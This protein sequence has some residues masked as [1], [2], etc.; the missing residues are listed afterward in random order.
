MD[1]IV[2]KMPKTESDSLNGINDSGIET[3]KNIPMLS[4]TKEE[5]QNSCDAWLKNG[6]PVEVHFSDFYMDINDIPSGDKLLEVYKQ[7]RDFWDDYM[8]ND[9]KVVEFFD[10]GISLLEK[11]KIRVLRISDYNTTGL[12]GIDGKSS[13]W[14]NLVKNRYVSDKPGYAGG[15][16]GI[17]KDAAFACSELRTVFYNTL[18]D[19]NDKAFQGT[20]RLPSYVYNNENYTGDGFFSKDDGN[21]KTNNAIRENISLEPGY[22]RN[23]TGMDKYIFGFGEELEKDNLKKEL[24]VSSINNYLY[25]FYTG[26]L[27]VKFDDVLVDKDHLE[28]LFIQYHDEIDKVTRD[29]YDVLK[30]PDRTET[31][32]VFDKDDV[33]IFVKLGNN[34]SRRAAVLR[35]TGMKVFDKDH[36]SGRIDF[37]AVVVLDGDNVNEYFK[38]LE[39][40]EHTQWSDYRSSSR[41]EASKKQNI[42]FSRL[43]EIIGELHIEDYE[44]RI[45]SEG[46]SEYLPFAYVTGKKSNSVDTLSNEIKEKKK[47]PKKKRKKPE[48]TF[49]EDELSFE[50]DEAGNIIEDTINVRKGKNV[51]PGPP[52]PNPDP[53]PTPDPDIDGI[54]TTLSISNKFIAKKEIPNNKF[55]FA[56]TKNSD[57]F[58]FAFIPKE[59]ISNCYLEVKISGEQNAYDTSIVNAKMDGIDA[60]I[61]G[62]K[63]Y[64]G[65]LNA[66]IKHSVLFNLSDK[67]EYS[68]EVSIY[69]S[70][71]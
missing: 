3:Y 46:T 57:E 49:D 5:L 40:A 71:D 29:Y 47:K 68:L 44:T 16:F 51:N 53:G 20:I 39:N 23:S 28:D 25:A 52:N 13:P 67:G 56:L 61:N 4:L 27:I 38:K 54:E 30:E 33:K 60:E 37:S 15:S 11:G 12:K 8:T 17:G 66:N 69:E 32:T 64:L 6:K 63:V 19:D 41:E 7:Q 26:R 35:Q 55:N 45:D 14:N 34:Y 24:I 59:D 10:N 62:S 1:G 42:F 43:K 48:T 9:K 50:K 18:N 36:I 58:M 21:P 31:V 22:I 2:L 65:S 70:K